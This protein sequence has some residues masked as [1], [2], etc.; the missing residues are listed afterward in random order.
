ML[1]EREPELATLSSLLEGLDAS[2]GKVVLIRGEA[3]IGKTTL[4][5]EFIRQESAHA[6]VL[7][8]ACDD[9]LTPQ[10][11]G[12]FW[13]IG[14]DEPT[15]LEPLMSGD[16]RGVL[17]AV[18]DLAS[19]SL[20]PAVLVL[21]DTQWA[22]EATLDA[23]KFLGRRMGRTNA[24]LILTYREGEVDVDHPLRQVI[25]NLPPPNLTRM[26]LA[27]LSPQAVAS[28]IGDK[29]FDVDE[30]R[31][32]TDG[33][34]LF[35]TEVVASGIDHVPASI[36]DSVLARAAKLSPG[37][38]RLIEFVSVIPGHAER[39]L[40]DDAIR[41]MQEELTEAGRQELLLFPRDTVTFPHELQRRT[42][43]SSLDDAERRRLNLVVLDELKGRSDTA[44]LAHHAREARDTASILQYAP[45]AA[46]TA[47]A[48]ESHR[49]AV[50][51]F[52]SLEPYLDEIGESDRSSILDDWGREEF[53]LDNAASVD[54]LDRSIELHRAAEDDEALA[55][56]LTFAARVNRA[57][58]RN[59]E[60]FAMAREAVELLEGHGSSIPQANA[61]ST[62]AF[63]TWL[64][65]EDVPTS[66]ELADRA[67]AVAEEVG[68]DEATILSLNTKGSILHSSGDMAGTE[69]V[70]ES[71]R[72]AEA[73]ELRY[74]EIRA[75]SNLAAMA[76]DIRDVARATDLAARTVESAARY[77]IPLL[78]ASGHTMRSE[79]LLW[80]GDWDTAENA[81]SAALG[82]N[83]GTE[84]IAWRVLG[85]V[86]ARKGASNA[87]L[88]L[89]R[90]WALAEPSQQLTVTDPAAGVL[91]EY[92]WLTEEVDDAW[93]GRLVEILDGGISIGHPWPSGAF[94]FWMWKLGMLTT[95]P[96]GTADFYAWIIKGDYQ[97]SAAFWAKRGIPYEQALALMHGSTQEQ[98]DAIRI[99]E[100]LGATATANRLRKQ[101]LE[102]GVKVPRGKS[103]TTREHAAGLTPRQTEVLDL[104][105][106]DLTNTQI[107]DRLFVSHRTVENHVA[108]ILLK[109]DA[110]NRSAAVDVARDQGMLTPN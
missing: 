69:L 14:R 55:R 86:Q 12:A 92:M 73:A 44:R 7:V 82:A 40:I 83:P 33:N 49:E 106:E 68:G 75:L 91:A 79:F 21:E 20:R 80:K 24:L 50:S 71:R 88:A 54:I 5:S 18:L 57:Y 78:E 81:A 52:R 89:E 87:R 13:D 105:A 46:R 27:P 28:L 17:E 2:G 56:T 95:A 26:Q 36:Q 67:M 15:I 107:A 85:T 34:P 45:E 60:A 65:T 77:D 93:M 99:F 62:L 58:L 51:H 42:I 53:I 1:L 35:V 3:G 94:A 9:L 97:K 61:V 4:V 10:P 70:E 48:I 22:D 38:R 72:R 59:D 43:E 25:G 6:Q 32:L 16:R 29:P 41:P 8:G 39:W 37:A 76:G 109:L 90:M 103:L 100:K 98:I 84:H 23:I 66:L 63:L 11:L 96:E 19:R 110:A 101:L 104:I 102:E 74:D 64:Y 31:A 108:A 30:V 47:M